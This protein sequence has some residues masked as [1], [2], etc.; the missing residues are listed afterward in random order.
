MVACLPAAAVQLSRVA[1]SPMT[2]ASTPKMKRK[3]RTVMSLKEE[4]Y[5]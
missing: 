4:A 1:F 2:A 5:V 3:H